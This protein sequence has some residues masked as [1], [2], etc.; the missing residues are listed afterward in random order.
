MENP[1]PDKQANR[2][3]KKA[4]PARPQIAEQSRPAGRDPLWQAERT[5]ST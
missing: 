3:F 5:R 2:M 4:G 1:F